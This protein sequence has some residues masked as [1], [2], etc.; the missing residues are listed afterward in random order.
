MPAI[1]RNDPDG[2][3]SITRKLSQAFV[4]PRSQIKPKLEHGCR[5]INLGSQDLRVSEQ[6]EPV[7]SSLFSGTIIV[8]CK[9]ERKSIGKSGDPLHRS[10]TRRATRNGSRH[11]SSLLLNGKCI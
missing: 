9:Q 2:S 10:C 3:K 6:V 8:K 5:I 11:I 7:T 1:C 4:Y